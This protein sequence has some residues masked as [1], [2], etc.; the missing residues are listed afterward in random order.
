MAADVPHSRLC[1][2]IEDEKTG[3]ARAACVVESPAKTDR[4]GKIPSGR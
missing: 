1:A 4:K 3:V 2:E